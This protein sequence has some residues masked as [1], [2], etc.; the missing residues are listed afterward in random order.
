L[1][2]RRPERRGRLPGVRGG[3]GCTNGETCINGKCHATC[4]PQFPGTCAACA[5][6]GATTGLCVCDSTEIH[7]EGQPCGVGTTVAACEGGLV[8]QSGK[9][10]RP[11]VVGDPNSCPSGYVCSSAGGTPAC[12]PGS[13]GNICDS[14]NGMQCNNGAT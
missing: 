6:E 12:V 13:A 4:N 11:C 9:C 7:T 3:T 14:C 8:C 5:A 1:G 2:L 10:A